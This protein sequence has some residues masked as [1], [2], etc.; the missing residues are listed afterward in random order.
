MKI[1]CLHG[2]RHSTKAL[3]NSMDGLI[4]KL[5]QKTIHLGYFSTPEEASKIYNIKAKELFGEFAILN[6]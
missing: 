2:F 4:I 6:S 1:L 5:N 3:K